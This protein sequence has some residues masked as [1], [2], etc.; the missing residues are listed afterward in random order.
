M[1][2]IK[3][4]ME[5]V[6]ARAEKMAAQA[7]KENSGEESTKLGMR[8]A[9]EYLNGSQQDLPALLEKQKEV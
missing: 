7:T 5:M 4:T 6:L 9:A 3:S 8:L 1:A 2:E